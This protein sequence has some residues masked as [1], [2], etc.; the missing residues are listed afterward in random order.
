[1][2]SAPHADGSGF[3]ALGPGECPLLLYQPHP[4]HKEVATVL[5]TGSHKR[6]TTRIIKWWHTLN[7]PG[8]GMDQKPYLYTIIMQKYNEYVT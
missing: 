6:G 1:M 8:E 4:L 3:I 7:L 2:C 5:M